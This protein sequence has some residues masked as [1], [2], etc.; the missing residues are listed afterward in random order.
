MDGKYEMGVAKN[1]A[2]EGKLWPCKR[3]LGFIL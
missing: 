3:S 2:G 1:G